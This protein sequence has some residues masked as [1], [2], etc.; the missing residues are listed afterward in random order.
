[1]KSQSKSITP[2]KWECDSP[3]VIM[4][5]DR[6]VV[7]LAQIADRRCCVDHSEL[8]AKDVHCPEPQHQLQGPPRAVLDQARSTGLNHKHLFTTVYP[9]KHTCG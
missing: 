3:H 4:L 6:S 8:R 5:P 1:M 2:H 7:V 9:G